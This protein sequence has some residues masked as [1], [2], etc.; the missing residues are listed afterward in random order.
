MSRVMLLVA[1]SGIKRATFAVG[2]RTRRLAPSLSAGRPQV[3]ACVSVRPQQDRHCHFFESGSFLNTH[4][5]RLP[6]WSTGQQPASSWLAWPRFQRGLN[7]KVTS[8]ERWSLDK[9]QCSAQILFQAAQHLIHVDGL[10]QERQP[11]D[12][13]S[14]PADVCFGGQGSQKYNRH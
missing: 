7:P 10:G 3:P 6:H 4:R 12:A 14:T 2:P 8:S 1:L 13:A 11:S 5:K 9:G